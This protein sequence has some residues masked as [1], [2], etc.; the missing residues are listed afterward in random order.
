MHTPKHLLNLL[1]ATAFL[2]SCTKEKPTP[3]P[4]APIF[5]ADVNGVETTF[6]TSMFAESAI[7]VG[8]NFNL[9]IVAERKIR[10]DSSI[11]IVFN[12]PDFTK[13]SASFVT[14]SLGSNFNGGF[15]EETKQTG[16]LHEAFNFFQDGSLR[17]EVD[18]N[19]QLNGNFNF[20]YFLFDRYVNKI[21]EV[22]FT[23]GRFEH[24]PILRN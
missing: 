21:G 11:F 23:N 10:S 5:K 8:N 3:T 20:V 22:H 18:A 9:K 7:A 13:T 19:G 4:A 15:V 16:S 17:V 2:S 24:L 14:Y 12:L 6:T 1:I